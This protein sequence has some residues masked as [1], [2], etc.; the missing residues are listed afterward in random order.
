MN[1]ETIRQKSTERDSQWVETVSTTQN[2]VEQLQQIVLNSVIST[3]NAK[4][5]TLDIKNFYLNTPMEKY[6]YLRLKLDQLP[7]D[8]IGQYELKEKI[9]I[10]GYV[11]IEV[12]KG[13]YGLPQVGL[14]AQQ[15]LEKRLEKYGYAQRKQTPGLW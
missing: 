3:P 6:E 7:A 13:M 4:F 2:I 14:L 11:Y 5:M 1:I 8:V 15:L 9:T 10:N 12:Q